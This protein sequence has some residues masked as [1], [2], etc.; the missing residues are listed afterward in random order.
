MISIP[1]EVLASALTAVTRASLKSSLMAAFALVRLDATANGELSLSCF[2]GETAARATV[3]AAA[4]D[5]LSVSVDAQTLKA[6]TDTLVG[7]VRLELVDKALVVLNGSNRTT[8]RLI[9]ESIPVIGSETATDLFSLSG[10]TLRSLCRVL[11]FASTDESRPMLQVMHLTVSDQGLVAQAADGFTAGIVTENYAEAR[12]K[13]TVSLPLSFARLLAALVEEKDTVTVQSVGD[14]RF[15]FHLTQA[16]SGRNLTLATVAPA[17]AFPAEQIAQLL[18]GAHAGTTTRMIIQKQVLLQTVRMVGAMGTQNTFMKVMNGVIKVASAATDT[19]QARN[20]LDG[21]A[22]G[23]DAKVW[24]SAAY[25]KR[26][27]DACK[28]ELGVQIGGDKK[29]V[30]LLEGSFTSILMPL[31]VD[32]KDPFADEDEPIAISLPMMQTVD[33]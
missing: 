4:S 15:L 16:E 27:V 8:L 3:Y 11:P 7:E 32:G 26:A 13:A 25:L 28:A 29:P 1:Q 30:L 21:T 31:F 23:A 18:Q 17:A 33:A 24:L 10:T 19:G 22:T 2:N 12:Q 9:E 5:D 6:V 14:N 20:V